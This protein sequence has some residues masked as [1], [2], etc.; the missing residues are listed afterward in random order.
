M[1]HRDAE[2]YRDIYPYAHLLG[3]QQGQ[4]VFLKLR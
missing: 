2:Y 1:D 3:N 4:A